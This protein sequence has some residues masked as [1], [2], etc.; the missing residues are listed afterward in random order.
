[1]NT[2]ISTFLP[3][4]V[5]VFERVIDVQAFFETLRQQLLLQTT[6]KLTPLT[7]GV[8]AGMVLGRDELLT[9]TLSHSLKVTGM[10][11]VISASGFNVGLVIWSVQKVLKPLFW[12]RRVQLLLMLLAVWGYVCL[13]GAGP[14]LLRAGTM[15]SLGMVAQ[16]RFRSANV[17]WLL[18]LTVLFWWLINPQLA[19]SVSFQLS[20]SATAGLIWVLPALTRQQR[21]W[22]ADRELG[23]ALLKRSSESSGL[24]PL[25]YLSQ[26]VQESLLLTVAAQS[27]T[28]PLILHYFGELSLLSFLANTTLLWLTPVITILGA[29]WLVITQLL[30]FTSPVLADWLLWP[31]TAL[32]ELCSLA[33]VVVLGGIARFEWGF[34]ELR[35]E[36]PAGAVLGWW[37]AVLFFIWRMRK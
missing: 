25:K 28:L 12:S 18:G 36:W 24:R 11:H 6:S 19:T 27:F 2:I 35:F 14:S 17:G 16:W 37:L 33:F 30:H 4:S 29:L 8:V 23:V 21:S 9:Q 5:S 34:I 15:T 3:I 13:A 26:Y 20:A 10:Q 31:L 1:M 32:L 22:W 7:A